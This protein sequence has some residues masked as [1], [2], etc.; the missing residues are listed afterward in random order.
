MQLTGLDRELA[1]ILYNR[2]PINIEFIEVITCFC[3]SLADDHL[4]ASPSDL[5]LPDNFGTAPLMCCS[6]LTGLRSK[7]LSAEAYP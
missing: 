5:K 3:R 2:Q 4:R 1:A 6:K 7:L